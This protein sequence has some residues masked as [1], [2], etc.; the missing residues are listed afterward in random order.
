MLAVANATAQ[1]HQLNPQLGDSQLPYGGSE[2]Q[3]QKANAII[4]IHQPN[5]QQIRTASGQFGFLNGCCW[6]WGCH[7]RRWLFRFPFASVD[8]FA[9]KFREFLS[10]PSP[11]PSSFMVSL[12]S[13]PIVHAVPHPPLDI[14]PLPIPYLACHSRMIQRSMAHYS[15][16]HP[17]QSNDMKNNEERPP[18]DLFIENSFFHFIIYI[19]IKILQC[20]HK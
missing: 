7:F 18:Q 16:P 8:H 5:S 12:F 10:L 9:A 6:K 1:H 15:P 17:N 11:F 14:L 3:Q 19:H 20:E 2:H 13:L 4:N